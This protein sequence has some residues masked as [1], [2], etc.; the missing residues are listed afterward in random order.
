MYN[1]NQK[2]RF[3]K[4]ASDMDRIINCFNKSEPIETL[5]GKDLSNFSESEIDKMFMTI[6]T[7]STQTLATMRNVFK[8]YTD[9]C[10]VNNL[11]LDGINHFDFFSINLLNKY[12]NS[13]WVE[14]KQLS[15][16]AFYD[17]IPMV[18]DYYAKFIGYCLWEGIKGP[19]LMEI[20]IA[21][22][23]DLDENNDLMKV[24]RRDK[25][26]NRIYHRTVPVSHELILTGIAAD[27]IQD[28]I[29]NKNGKQVKISLDGTTIL[30]KKNQIN[31]S[32]SAHNDYHR[33]YYKFQV[34][35]KEFDMPNLTLNDVTT[36]GLAYKLKKGAE[37]ANCDITTFLESDKAKLILK[38][39]DV[40]YNGAALMRKISPYL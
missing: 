31:V 32:D 13:Y 39:Y 3:L 7:P 19:S 26:G 2:E 9:W 40:K 33:M 24:Y 23:E 38:N 17:M 25:K 12:V 29:I 8:R 37:E 10:I 6:N 35:R 4:S 30:K 34:L 22:V 15:P 36:N 1:E 16:E 5:L 27:K 11:V 21:K 28:D 18:E 14:S 20:A